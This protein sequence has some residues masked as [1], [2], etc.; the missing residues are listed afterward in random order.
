VIPNVYVETQTSVTKGQKWVA[1][2]RSKPAC[3]CLSVAKV[4]EKRVDCC[5]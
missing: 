5:Y 1:P 3:L 2:R 4:L